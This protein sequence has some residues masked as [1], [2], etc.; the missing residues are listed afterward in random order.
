MATAIRLILSC[1]EKGTSGF[2]GRLVAWRKPR[3]H[4]ASGGILGSGVGYPDKVYSRLCVIDHISVSLI[5]LL[6][7]GNDS[8]GAAIEPCFCKS[9]ETLCWGLLLGSDSSLWYRNGGVE[10]RR[11]LHPASIELVSDEGGGNRL[12]S[13]M[14]VS[15]STRF[16]HPISRVVVLALSSGAGESAARTLWSGL[17]GL[18]TMLC[19][20]NDHHFSVVYA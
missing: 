9:D 4:R 20:G 7:H 12:D 17:V 19:R 3:V 18:V 13:C 8:T 16:D 6:A 14:A 1:V 5:R 11:S 15:D 10:A 2:M